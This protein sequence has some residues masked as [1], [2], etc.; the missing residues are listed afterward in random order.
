VRPITD[1]E[2]EQIW[3][4]HRAGVPV[5]RIARIMGRQNCSM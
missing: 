2:K 1:E 5:K 3:D 4:M